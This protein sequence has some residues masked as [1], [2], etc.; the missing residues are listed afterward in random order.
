MAG[1][2]PSGSSARTSSEPPTTL[3]PSG[4]P[5]ACRSRRP[6]RRRRGLT[7]P[8]PCRLWPCQRGLAHD[9]DSQ[10]S[11]ADCLIRLDNFR[12]DHAVDGDPD[13]RSQPRIDRPLHQ[14]LGRTDDA[15]AGGTRYPDPAGL[16]GDDGH[17]DGAAGLASQVDGEGVAGRDVG[18]GS[19]E[20][21]HVLVEV[22]L[23]DDL[24]SV[25]GYAAA[26]DPGLATWPVV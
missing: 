21:R 22:D 11:E 14:D 13:V 12:G 4:S 26:A 24:D 23:A 5:A 9:G 10:I 8:R 16:H 1:P 7:S 19:L 6:C 15:S 18:E 2:R 25:Y 20:M 17:G 3:T